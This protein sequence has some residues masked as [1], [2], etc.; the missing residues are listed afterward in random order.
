MA[1]FIN[2]KITVNFMQLLEHDVTPA[3]GYYA[4]YDPISSCWEAKTPST[5]ELFRYKEE[6]SAYLEQC[7]MAANGNAEKRPMD[8]ENSLL[9]RYQKLI[10]NNK[11][12]NRRCQCLQKRCAKYRRRYV[13]VLGPAKQWEEAAK[14]RYYKLAESQR[15]LSRTLNKG[16]FSIYK[17]TW[18]L[19]T[20][21]DAFAVFF[22]RARNLITSGHWYSHKI[23]EEKDRLRFLEERFKDE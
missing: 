18:A 1:N 13:A 2:N 21:L 23:W 16:Y 20:A 7:H 12:L 19:N 11:R 6:A 15:K 17:V 10:E 22:Q 9:E 14:Q 3:V 4:F 5:N 8:A